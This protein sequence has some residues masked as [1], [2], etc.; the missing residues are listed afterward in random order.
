[1]PNEIKTTVDLVRIAQ[2]EL[3]SEHDNKALPGAIT[4]E[5]GYKGE[6]MSGKA[7]THFTTFNHGVDDADQSFNGISVFTGSI[8]GRAGTVAFTIAGGYD[9]ASDVVEAEYVIL[10]ASASGELK[11][12]KGA[13]HSACSPGKSTGIPATFNVE[14]A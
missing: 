1:M 2:L 3:T 6:Q 4:T 7:V 13:G 12:I 11:G 9:K 14:F 10:G 5:G 8:L